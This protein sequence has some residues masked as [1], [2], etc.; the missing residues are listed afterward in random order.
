[1]AAAALTRSSA[2][3]GEVVLC[4]APTHTTLPAVE[5]LVR[6]DPVWFAERE[7]ADRRELHLPPTVSMAAVAGERRAVESALAHAELPAGVE[8]L[9]PL[10]MG[11]DAVRVLLR[12]PLEQAPELAASLA[13]M[14][15]VRSARKE[16]TGVQVVVDP[17]DLA[18]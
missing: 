5:S 8:R 6:W 17:P 1:M 9:G 4:G 16:A 7:L 10:P 2:L 12:S 13:A 11:P 14:R 15:A 18:S 3:G